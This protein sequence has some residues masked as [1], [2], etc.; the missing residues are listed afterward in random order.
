MQR[1]RVLQVDPELAKFENHGKGIGSKVLKLMGWVPGE[2]LGNRNEG[3]SEPLNVSMRPKRAGLGAVGV[4]PSLAPTCAPKS[5][6]QRMKQGPCF[7]PST[8]ALLQGTRQVQSDIKLAWKARN[9][10]KG[11]S[12]NSVN[13]V[14]QLGM[15]TSVESTLLPDLGA[16]APV[17]TI[18]DFTGPQTSLNSNIEGLQGVLRGQHDSM[19]PFPE[20]QHNLKLLVDI[21]E[22]E[23]RGLHRQAQLQHSECRTLLQQAKELQAEADRLDKELQHSTSV[24]STISLVK[25]QL[26]KIDEL[27][28]THK[29]LKQSFPE[30]FMKFNC[31]AIA[32]FQLLPSI[33]QDLATWDVLQEPLLW[34]SSFADWKQLLKTEDNGMPSSDRVDSGLTAPLY[35]PFSELL[36]QALVPPLRTSIMAKWDP[37]EPGPLV[38]FFDHWNV[39]LPVSVSSILL[40]SMVLPSVRACVN[41]WAQDSAHATAP[42]AHTWLHPWLQY[43]A[44]ELQEFYPVV[45]NVLAQTLSTWS[46]PDPTAHARISP[47]K[48]VWKASEWRN[49]TNLTVV[50]ALEAAMHDML[51]LFPKPMGQYNITP[52]EW[53]SSWSDLLLQQQLAGIYERAFFPKLHT[54]AHFWL[55]NS[56]E[57]NSE[58]VGVWLHSQHQNCIPA[59]L[60]TDCHTLH[61]MAAAIG[62]VAQYKKHRTLPTGYP[63][64]AS[65]QQAPAV[66]KTEDFPDSVN[67]SVVDFL[68]NKAEQAGLSFVPQHGRMVSGLQVYG[69]GT[70]LVIVDRHVGVIKVLKAHRWVPM[71]VDELIQLAL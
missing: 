3:I 17:M 36:F 30:E 54:V 25:P 4:E 40:R 2:G 21:T 57:V 60:Q 29:E 32:V 13:S 39:I 46:P 10:G 22:G 8:P 65:L 48:D 69:L 38:Q 7:I 44:D 18:L 63:T 70:L 52:C 64:V 49:F 42:P 34:L 55:L 33:V 37:F 41:R 19:I 45:R 66:L 67:L 71:T 62:A 5:D 1:K 20:L 43:L 14:E 35:D 59:L 28:A 47:W 51:N 61:Q 11:T 23:I 15:Q 58:E 24:L 31:A 68:E 16:G 50:P 53:C 12:T 27:L 9:R 6:A 56:A 26:V